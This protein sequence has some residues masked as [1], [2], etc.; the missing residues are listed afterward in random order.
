MRI[1]L[2]LPLEGVR[3]EDITTFFIVIVTFFVAMTKKWP[4][5]VAKK[6]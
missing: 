5:N 4:F 6:Q 2:C 3:G 1:C